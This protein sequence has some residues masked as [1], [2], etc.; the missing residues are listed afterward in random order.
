ML[1]S[2]PII[3]VYL[4]LLYICHSYVEADTI[5]I[6][7]G[8]HDTNILNER[9]KS[10]MDYINTNMSVINECKRDGFTNQMTRYAVGLVGAAVGGYICGPNCALMG[11]SIGLAVGAVVAHEFGCH[12]DKYFTLYLSG[13]IKN[14]GYDSE[15]LQM[16]NMFAY[17]C[18]VK[19]VQDKMAKNT[20]ENFAYLKRWIHQNYYIDEFP[21]IVISTSDFHKNR[22][23]LI[24]NGI[25]PE[26]NPIWNLSVSKCSSCWNDERIH[27]KNIDNDIAKTKHMY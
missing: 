9:V 27:I 5:I 21:N 16:N 26:A 23:E 14:D 2:F 1:F 3:S 8:S 11:S 10:T 25:F 7:L 20:A 17:D 19:I 24:F 12:R 4:C 15:A 13:G 22:A 18:N 6:V